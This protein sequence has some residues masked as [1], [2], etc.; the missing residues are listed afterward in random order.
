MIFCKIKIKSLLVI[1]LLTFT[2]C[3]LP[4]QLTLKELA[5]N[6]HKTISHNPE[7]QIASEAKSDIKTYAMVTLSSF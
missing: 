2:K 6:N 7:N 3:Y 5:Y 4:L 1:E